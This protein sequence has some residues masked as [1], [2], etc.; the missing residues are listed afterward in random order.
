MFLIIFV[1]NNYNFDMISIDRVYK[2]VLFF[3]NSDVIGNVKPD[4]LRLAINTAVE[5]IEES[6][7]GDLIRSLNR[8]NRG[9]D[10]VGLES[11]SEKIRER[12]QY[13]LVDDGVSLTYTAGKF[14]LPSDLRYMDN[15]MYNDAEIEP[16][17]NNKEFKSISNLADSQ[18][19][20]SYPIYL[21]VGDNVKIA[22]STIV[23]NV[24]ISYLRKHAI[25]NWTFN[26][27]G[28]AEV[29]NPSANDFQDIDLHP[30]EEYAVIIKTCGYFGVNLKDSDIVNMA[31]QAQ[32]Q[33]FN[34]DNV[35]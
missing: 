1:Y 3:V 10:G 21:R 35:S 26:V 12:I 9:L 16:C 20:T 22:P 33:D 30:S 2:A 15:L 31:G 23:D 28:D 8:K 29:F 11:L 18:P 24:T 19:T 17:K 5:D 27:I 14:E 4:D 7:F 13:H 32:Q 6:Y 34:E 25:A